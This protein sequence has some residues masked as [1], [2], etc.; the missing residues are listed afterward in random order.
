M[1]LRTLRTVGLFAGLSVFGAL[2]I[3]QEAPVS[4]CRAL[5]RP[6]MLQQQHDPEQLHSIRKF[7]QDEADTGVIDA[8]YQLSFFYL[9]LLEWNEA[10][11]IT[12]I[13]NSAHGG[14]PEAQY[15]LAWQ[16]DAGPLLPDSPEQAL[17]WYEAAAARDHRLALERLASVYQNGELGQRA[18]SRKAANF[19]AR[20]ARCA[21]Q[22]T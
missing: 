13:T 3:A 21:N 5:M 14:V 19:R 22:Q 18:D 4:E 7:C 12:L 20:A 10:K 9:G 6:V 17:R 16:Y 11:A 2:A 15:W 1:V 8:E